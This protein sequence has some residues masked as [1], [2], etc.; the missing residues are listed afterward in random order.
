M[1]ALGL[2]STLFELTTGGDASTVAPGEIME[3]FESLRAYGKLPRGRERR[4]QQ[5]TDGE[6]ATAILGLV[7]RAAHR[8]RRPTQR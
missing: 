2:A 6:I 8:Q 4:N 1:I 7:W 3:R 5:L